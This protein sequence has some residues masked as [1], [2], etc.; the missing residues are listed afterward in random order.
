[1]GSHA[2][3]FWYPLRFC[4]DFSLQLA[5]TLAR[6]KDLKENHLWDAAWVSKVYTN[7]S[8]S[9]LKHDIFLPSRFNDWNTGPMES[10]MDVPFFKSKFLCTAWSTESSHRI[11]GLQSLAWMM[12]LCLFRKRVK[13]CLNDAGESGV[14][15]PK[16]SF[17]IVRFHFANGSKGFPGPLGVWNFSAEDAPL[18]LCGSGF[19]RGTGWSSVD[20]AKG[21][22]LWAHWIVET[23]KIWR[24]VWHYLIESLFPYWNV[25][26]QQAAIS[27]R[28]SCPHQHQNPNE[29][30]KKRKFRRFLA[31]VVRHRFL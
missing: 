1:M 30:T 6:K 8:C 28:I 23:K 20:S 19:L 17:F 22:T 21:K 11:S 27:T 4:R 2:I 31:I 12:L 7:N 18:H 29:A 25:W 15:D 5:D 3:D 26:T 14:L 16:M 9:R 10:W 24:D 13:R